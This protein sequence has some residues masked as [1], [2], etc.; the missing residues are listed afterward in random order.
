MCPAV[1]SIDAH[2]QEQSKSHLC[3]EVKK[4]NRPVNRTEFPRLAARVDEDVHADRT[5]VT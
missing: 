5:A 2:A 4:L 1:W 3:E